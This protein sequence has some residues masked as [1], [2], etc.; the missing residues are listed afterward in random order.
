MYTNHERYKNKKDS[1]L[2]LRLHTSHLRRMGEWSSQNLCSHH[3]Q[4][5]AYL[6]NPGLA[7]VICLWLIFHVSVV[8][9]LLSP[10]HFLLIFPFN[11]LPLFLN[12]VSSETFPVFSGLFYSF[13][14]PDLL[15]N[16]CFLVSD[17]TKDCFQGNITVSMT[18]EPY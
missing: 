16:M 1:R 9:N 14:I 4:P 17:S 2:S 11:S 10:I 6:H 7:Q 5:R 18:G 3:V 15:K 8:W 13:F 12:Q